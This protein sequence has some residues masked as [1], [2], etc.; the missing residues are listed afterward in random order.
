LT[1][2]ILRKRLL[3]SSM[4][5]GVALAAASAGGANAQTTPPP[6]AASTATAAPT[7]GELVVTGSRIPQA[8]L[9]SVSPVTTVNQEAIKL[10]GAINIEDFV[11]NLP[12][13]FADFGQYESN[14][15]SGTATVDLRG[16][17]NTRTLVLIDGKREQ[18]GDPLTP[19]ADLNFIPP[20]LI[21]RVEVLTGG[22]S[23]VYGSDAVA[24]VVNFIM[25]HD[26]QGLQLDVTTSIGEHNNSPN[27][28]ITAANN[29]PGLGPAESVKLAPITLPS[30]T[31]WEGLRTT[32]T[33][34]GGSNTPDDKGNVEFYL[35]YT[36]IEPVLEGK[37]N[38]SS[39]SLSTNT[40][41][42]TQQYCGGSVTAAG[43]GGGLLQVLSGP[44]QAAPPGAYFGLGY[45]ITGT[46]QANGLLPAFTAADL[47]NFAPLNYIQ[48]PDIRY[49]AG[50]YSHYEISPA[51]DLYSSF[52]FMD[53]HTE[54]QI[55]GS[56]SFYGDNVYTIPCNDPL[57]N[58]TQANTLCG[59]GPYT[60]G[61]T[62]SALIGRRDVEGVGRVS[63]ITHFDYRMVI[64]AKGDLGSAWHYDVSGQYG[65]SFLNDIEEG[66]FI[67]PNLINAID[68]IPNPAVGGIA[69]I[70]TGA[71][72]CAAAVSGAAPKCV[73]YNIWTAGGVTP[74]QL[75]YLEGTAEYGGYT[76]EQVV[77][78]SITGD[79]GHY[80]IKSPWA[81]D[82]VGISVGAEY[83]R[84]FLS[85]TPDQVAQSGE[86][87]GFGGS[88]GATEGS[89]S[90]DDIF[91]ELRVPLVQNV[92][93]IKELTFEGGYR[94]SDYT[95]GGGNSTYKIGGDWQVIPDLRIR[96]SYERAV[97]A[98]NVDE[99]FSPQT[100]GLIAG[101]D[102]C[103]GTN[104]VYT[105]AQCYNTFKNSFPN[106]TLAQYT[107][108]D[109]NTGT[110][111]QCISGQCGDLSGGN[112]HLVPEVA[113]TKSIGF[114]FT[115]TFFRGF[116]LT[117]DYFDIS[118]A[119]AIITL[120]ANLILE[121]C[122]LSDQNCNLIVRNPTNLAI[123]G[124]N[125]AGYLDTTFVNAESLNTKGIDVNAI[126]RVALRDWH[127]PDDG[128]LTLNFNGTWVQNLTTTL[129]GEVYN[130][131]GLY[132]VTCGTPTPH[133]RSETRLTWST[134]WNLSLS[135]Q[136]RFLSATRL[137]LNSD[138]P[139][140]QGAPGMSQVYNDERI[141]NFS[142]FD[143][144]FN[145]RIRDR[146]SLRGGINNIFDRTPPLV[147]SNSFAISAPPFGNANTYPQVFDPLG[148]V[149]FMGLTADF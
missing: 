118:V 136:W 82:G 70:A 37:Y 21:D 104:A 131:A 52:M 34:T 11:N 74:A 117:L 76:T 8:N 109:Y 5:S 108:A 61:Q 96:A 27:P 62:A 133:Y 45:A 24:G 141:P 148:R 29:F 31:A 130:C 39:C 113:N 63:D 120:P 140:L 147:S 115:P 22:A 23:A 57:L 97:R 10:Q 81:T 51:L 16:L 41:V 102:P 94:Y 88:L 80:G 106:L 138:Q 30:G 58:A 59:P 65:Q 42:H 114:V 9:V 1:H 66:Y 12:Q 6:A 112:P 54:A 38:W 53:D 44:H 116:S 135:V 100:P 93:F 103:A 43:S 20:S 105:A 71:P 83:R 91:G 47:Y 122:A 98:P 32:V 126:Y 33:I 64:G 55:A 72:V 26:F 121:G 69:G 79:L 40:G 89:Q 124:G 86:L 17:G 4:I 87:A 90:D 77:T 2:S 99:L 110:V 48:R 25:K 101:A 139:A 95:S 75:A 149:F 111:A 56:G 143:L 3:A 127:L 145:Y 49:N 35:A 125:G 50:E 7:V 128:S 14:G 78:G 132:G 28:V 85:F 142:Y 92:P 60:A 67:N 68:V 137:D 119:K 36:S 13:A 107:A 123:Y 129:P 18:P 144:A 146:Y 19:V 84:E 15:S 46:P 73:P 134:P